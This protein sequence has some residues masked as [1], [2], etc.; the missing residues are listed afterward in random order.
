MPFPAASRLRKAFKSALGLSFLVARGRHAACLAIA[1]TS[2][3]KHF[4]QMRRKTGRT[5]KCIPARLNV[6][7]H[8]F[9]KRAFKFAKRKVRPRKQKMP[10]GPAGSN[11]K[12]R[13]HF[14][15]KCFNMK[16]TSWFSIVGPSRT[17]KCIFLS[18]RLRETFAF[19]GQKEQEAR[20]TQHLSKKFTPQSALLLQ[21]NE[22]SKSY[23][24]LM[25]SHFCRLP[26]SPRDIPGVTAA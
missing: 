21:D 8:I 15:L 11:P 9:K 20:F 26:P 13:V 17:L 10:C 5:E 7:E 18:K 4:L 19:G 24:K 1:A 22:C 16:K 25:E 14:P 12:I 3:L 6:A 23:T 2:I